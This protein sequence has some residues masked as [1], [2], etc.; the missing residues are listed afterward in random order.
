LAD[1]RGRSDE[2][3]DLFADALEAATAL[4][5]RP[6]EA[7]ILLEWSALVERVGNRAKAREL[8]AAGEALA[9]TLEG[10]RSD[11]APPTTSDRSVD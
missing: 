11:A 6:T 1:V 5:A 3:A 4:G 9:S 10:P 7:R 2:A 8:R